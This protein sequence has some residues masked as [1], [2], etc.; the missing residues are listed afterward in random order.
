MRIKWNKEE[1]EEDERGHLL[2]PFYQG[3]TSY[4]PT[5]GLKSVDIVMWNVV[6]VLLGLWVF[7]VTASVSYDSK[8]ITINGHRRILISGSIH[9]P[10]STPEVQIYALSPEIYF[11]F[12]AI[13]LRCVPFLFISWVIT[14]IGICFVLWVSLAVN[15]LWNFIP[16]FVPPPPPPPLHVLENFSTIFL[17]PLLLAK[18]THTSEIFGIVILSVGYTRTEFLKPRLSFSVQYI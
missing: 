6:S 11:V 7:T 4:D 18:G 14:H 17:L 16:N 13:C 12:P 5:M 15:I 3:V 9:Y 10:R 1:G 2:L 8:A